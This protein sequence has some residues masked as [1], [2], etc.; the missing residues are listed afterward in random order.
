LRSAVNYS[1]LE[2]L[3]L[4]PMVK[5]KMLCQHLERGISDRGTAGFV[6]KKKECLN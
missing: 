3:L 2:K 6:R 5:E 4:G 1:V